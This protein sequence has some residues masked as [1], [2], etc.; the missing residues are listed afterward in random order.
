MVA[1]ICRLWLSS[2]LS[3]ALWTAAAPSGAHARDVREL[4]T[5]H[6]WEDG[7]GL[8]APHDM[9]LDDDELITPSGWRSALSC[10]PD[11]GG[12]SELCSELLVPADWSA[13]LRERAAR[14]HA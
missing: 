6:G 10:T 13:G 4:I 3:A 9:A 12:G 2:L 1:R 8:A 14:P 5:P 11:L 7:R